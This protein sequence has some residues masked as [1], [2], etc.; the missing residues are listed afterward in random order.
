MWLDHRTIRSFIP[1]SDDRSFMTAL[2]RHF[3]LSLLCLGSL[4]L[5]ACAPHEA[6]LTNRSTQYLAAQGRFVGQVAPQGA[7]D[8]ISYWDGSGVS[9]AP[10][11]EISIARQQA[12]FYKGNQLVGVSAVS[13]GR[14]GK[15]TPRGSFKVTQKSPAHKSNLYGD[16]VDAAGNVV[17][18]AVDN[19]KDPQPAGT[20]F[21][22]ASMPHFMRFHG[23]VGSHGG[24]LPGYPASAGC[25][26]MPYHMAQVFYENAPSDTPVRVY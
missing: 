9:G 2:I 24:F 21:R 4:L 18:E 8:T 11:I 22:G 7:P 20:T 25:V 12:Y 16:Y 10:R 3:F 19:R 14:V 6:A 5:G 17:V 26:R 15:E 1:S 23:A 13:T